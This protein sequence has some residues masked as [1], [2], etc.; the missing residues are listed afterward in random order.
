LSGFLSIKRK[1]SRLGSALD[2]LVESHFPRLKRPK[3]YPFVSKTT[4]RVFACPSHWRWNSFAPKPSRLPRHRSE[5]RFLP[6]SANIAGK[7]DMITELSE[8]ITHSL[9]ASTSD[10]NCVSAGLVPHFARPIATL[11]LLQHRDLPGLIPALMSTYYENLQFHVEPDSHCVVFRSQT[12]LRLEFLF[13][14]IFG[15]ARV[16]MAVP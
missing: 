8:A 15:R 7:S 2:L 16:Q 9:R 13:P 3:R 6:N 4:V 11:T 14:L 5:N 10:S 1:L 12:P